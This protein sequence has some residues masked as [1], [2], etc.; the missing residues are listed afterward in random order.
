MAVAPATNQPMNSPRSFLLLALLMLGYLLWAQ[1]QQ[2]YGPGAKAISTTTSVDADVA[3]SA[4]SSDLPVAGAVPST[5]DIPDAP[6]VPT[7]VTATPGMV[8]GTSS[9]RITVTTDVL[10]VEID[11]RGGNVVIAD[12][13]AYPKDPKRADQ[14][15]RLFD[16]AGA[17]FYAAQSGLVSATG[18]APNHQAEFSIERND[19]RLSDGESAVEVPMTWTDPSGIRVRKVFR[20]ERGSYVIDQRQEIHNGSAATW[21]ATSYQQL[22]RV[23]IVFD[24]SGIKAYTN[25]EHYSF[26]GAADY[27]P[28]EKF[29]KLPFT[30]FVKEPLNRNVQGGWIA[31]IQHYFFAAWI[32]PA[33]Q[34]ATFTTSTFSADGATRYLVR[35]T[36]AP[37]QVAA[38]ADHV[39]NARLYVGPKLQSTIDDVA[40]GLSLTANYGMFTIISKPLHWVLSLLHS[41]TGNWGFAIILL[42]VLIKLVFFKL[43]EAQFRSM[44]KMRKLQPRVQALKDR[45]GDDRQKMN[46]AMME[47]YQKE[48]INPL[49]GC[50]PLLIQMPVFFAL[51]WVLLESVELRHAPFV[52][53]IHNLT[54]PDPYYVLPILNAATMI[55]TQ[56]L[57]PMT[58]MDPT[59]AKIMKVM[60]VVFSVLFAFFPAGLV[61]YWTTNGMLSLIQQW[62]ITKR[63]EAGD[64]KAVAAK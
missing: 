60:P 1:W 39:G 58:G 49:G 14:P 40:P 22:Q 43:S 34:P 37:I 12:L 35:S 16:D 52:G 27:S 18:A 32:P 17:T 33:D 9:P 11:S 6:P 63:V 56:H 5:A 29:Q 21:S 53:W 4:T 41:I 15:V 59:Q 38:G 61:L 46:T 3:S 44:A 62:V 19:Y 8:A 42:V 10:R 7:A 36:S 47:L 50:L 54:A 28:Q 51:Y 64:A 24:V 2:D 57:T 26:V 48:K 45:Y 25:T 13:L 55:L 23:P 31:M 30:D 20:F